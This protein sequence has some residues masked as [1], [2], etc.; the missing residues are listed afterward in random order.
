M[1]WGFCDGLPMECGVELENIDRAKHLINNNF[2]GFASTN[3]IRNMKLGK[4]VEFLLQLDLPPF[5]R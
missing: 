3:S 2:I 5:A 1:H 4:Y